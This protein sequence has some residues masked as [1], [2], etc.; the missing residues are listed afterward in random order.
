MGEHI[1]SHNESIGQDF[2]YEQ[3][4]VGEIVAFD[5]VYEY[6]VKRARVLS[7]QLSRVPHQ[8]C[9]RGLQARAS[10]MGTVGLSPS[11]F[12]LARDQRAT[13]VMGSIGQP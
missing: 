13:V 7:Q 2:G 8:V 12:N 3:F 10:D 6:E 9:H 1:V 11:R 4:E 5:R